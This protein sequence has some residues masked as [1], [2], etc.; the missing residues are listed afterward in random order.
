[1]VTGPDVNKRR[2]QEISGNLSSLVR[3]FNIREGMKPEDD[4][5]SSGLFRKLPGIENQLTRDELDQMLQDYYQHR[6]WNASGIPQN[7]SMEGF[8]K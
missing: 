6:G 3:Q 4:Y 5:L 2:L 8:V 7:N 1:M